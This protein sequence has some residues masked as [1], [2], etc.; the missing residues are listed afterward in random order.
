MAGKTIDTGRPTQP[1]LD[2]LNDFF[3]ALAERAHEF[4]TFGLGDLDDPDNAMT[5]AVGAGGS[6][7]KL[8]ESLRDSLTR[9]PG[10]HA[11]YLVAL[12]DVLDAE[13][14]ATAIK[15]IIVRERLPEKNLIGFWADFMVDANATDRVANFVRNE[16]DHNDLAMIWSAYANRP[17]A[18]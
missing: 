17:N 10:D 6:A 18:N 14:E 4:V 5:V 13:T 3:T 7:A 9:K 8:P 1:R 16:I 11:E 15:A 12:F 2:T